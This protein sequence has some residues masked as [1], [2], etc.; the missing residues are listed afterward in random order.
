[1]LNFE[2]RDCFLQFG[3]LIKKLYHFDWITKYTITW[4]PMGTCTKYLSYAGMYYKQI[5]IYKDGP[6]IP[7]TLYST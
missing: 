6:Y 4:R 3:N 5:E 7:I 2:C 1:M